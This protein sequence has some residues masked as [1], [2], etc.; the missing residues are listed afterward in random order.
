MNQHHINKW[1][2]ISPLGTRLFF[3]T[4][5]GVSIVFVTVGT[6]INFASES[7]PTESSDTVTHP[8]LKLGSKGTA[9]SK[10]QAALKLLGYY[11]GEVD[12]IYGKSTAESVSKF[13]QAAGLTA[14]GIVGETTWKRLFPA[15]PITTT[16]K[17][18]P[19]P[20]PSS[21]PQPEPTSTTTIDLPTLR[22]GMRGTAVAGLQQRLKS[23]GLFSDDIDGIFGSKTELAVKAF[24]NKFKIKADGI[25]GKSSWEA[26]LR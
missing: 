18:T 11:K 9:V 3:S 1:L 14:D 12:G 10:L 7:N 21:E 2:N 22:L 23:L 25:V 6:Q 20:T 13:Q 24:Q 26:I 17:P 16:P 15:T 8:T 4:I 19:S 5:F